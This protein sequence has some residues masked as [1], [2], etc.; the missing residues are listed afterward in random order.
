MNL[1]FSAVV[2]TIIVLPGFVFWLAYR[3]EERVYIGTDASLPLRHFVL[4]LVAAAL[5]HALWLPMASLVV[6]P[7]DLR[8]DLRSAIILPAGAGDE[9]EFR[10]AV[11]SV[12]GHPCAVFSYFATLNLGAALLGLGTRYVA[13]KYQVDKNVGFLKLNLWFY[14]LQDLRRQQTPPGYSKAG[15][16]VAAVVVLGNEAFICRGIYVD[17]TLDSNG[18]LDSI[19]LRY[20]HRRRLS[21]D[22]SQGTSGGYDPND[23]RYYRMTGDRF[24]MKYSDVK[25]MTLTYVAIRRSV[26]T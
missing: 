1:A 19:V 15:V 11:T 23:S 22:R 26:N 7:F 13:R 10:H 16:V 21:E 20:A 5:L 6:W 2:L 17:S 18:E 12:S 14:L 3:S 24:V 9:S 4:S 25:T 8:I